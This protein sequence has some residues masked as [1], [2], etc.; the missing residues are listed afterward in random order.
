M[1]A[2][3]HHRHIEQQIARE[4]AIDLAKSIIAAEARLKQNREQLAELGE[5]LAPGLQAQPGWD[6]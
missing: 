4:E 6:L 3:P 1:L 2:C 5:Q